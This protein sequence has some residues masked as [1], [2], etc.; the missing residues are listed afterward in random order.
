M[1][2]LTFQHYLNFS[3]C[4]KIHNGSFFYS[5]DSD[6]AWFRLRGGGGGGYIKITADN[7]IHTVW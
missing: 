5:D 7:G 1:F 3:D 2:Y 4:G 6:E